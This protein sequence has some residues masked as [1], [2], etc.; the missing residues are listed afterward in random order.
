MKTAAIVRQRRHTLYFLKEIRVFSPVFIDTEIDM[1]SVQRHRRAEREAGQ[2]FSLVAYVVYAAARAL[3]A[4]PEANV[5]LRGRLM[6]RVLRSQVVNAKLAMDKTIGGQRAVLATVIPNADTAGLATIQQQID[7]FREGDP[8]RMPEWSAARLLHRMPWPL[9]RVVFGLAVRLRP[10]LLG[11]LAITSL[12]HRPVD[13]FQSVG[14][15]T[16]TLGVGRVL[17]RP[18][19]RDGQVVVAPVMRLSLA[20]D[21]RA[22]DGA[23]AADL[24]A[25]IKAGLEDFASVPTS[26]ADAR[27]GARNGTV[28]KESPAGRS[29]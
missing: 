14:G 19:A 8:D 18:V 16:V 25:D 12:G 5:A 13:G 24:L 10:L 15:T 7:H 26:S 22:I 3:A 4:H 11:T 27:D 20:F 6:P 1:S 9:G 29:V 23:E 2:H 21:H 28:T 17:E